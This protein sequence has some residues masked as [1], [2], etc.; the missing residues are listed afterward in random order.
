MTTEFEEY[1]VAEVLKDCIEQYKKDSLI[2]YKVLQIV[3]T[4][5]S[6]P[7]WP[8]NYEE[9]KSISNHILKHDIESL[10]V[11]ATESFPGRKRADRKA[12]WT[13]E[14]P[15]GFKD[16]LYA[17]FIVTI[18]II[19]QAI[20]SRISPLR[21]YSLVRSG[22]PRNNTKILKFIR[23]DGASLDIEVVREDA[24]E[25]IRTLGIMISD[26]CEID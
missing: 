18:P 21:F 19:E 24:Q 7:A 1:R 15:E 14:I 26:S 10:M 20:I 8:H 4:L 22:V 5:K 13:E 2:F 25:I 6:S 16:D 12:I 3:A 23:M 9:L 17:F 11:I